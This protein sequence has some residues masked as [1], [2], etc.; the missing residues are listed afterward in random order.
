MAS[1]GNYFKHILFMLD[2]R[3][4]RLWRFAVWNIVTN[5]SEEH[6]L[7]FI[8]SKLLRECK[9]WFDTTDPA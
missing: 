2:L 1:E 9:F 8:H 7:G 5:I 4:S 3:N 6:A